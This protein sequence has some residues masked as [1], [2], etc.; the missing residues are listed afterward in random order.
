MTER[1]DG[2]LLRNIQT[3]L[4]E[5]ET[6]LAE[7]EDHWSEPDLV[8]RYY[9][10]SYKVY[11]IQALTEKMVALLVSVDPKPKDSRGGRFDRKFQ[12]IIDAG[13]GHT[14]HVNHNPEWSKRGRPML[15]AFWHAKYA[16]VHAVD[17][18]KMGQ[19]P[20]MLPS[21]WAGLLSIIGI[22]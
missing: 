6:V 9:H 5:F 16:L 19:A 22:R 3:R 20:N 12:E 1:L 2:R 11:G 13:T 17:A 7:V 18:A 4:K 14:F 10:H 21:G 8:Y 15:E